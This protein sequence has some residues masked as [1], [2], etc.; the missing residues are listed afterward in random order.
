M[1]PCR[2]TDDFAHKCSHVECSRG[3]DFD[4]LQYESKHPSQAS[5]PTVNSPCSQPNLD[6][7]M[8]KPGALG[9]RLARRQSPLIGSSRSES[10]SVTEGNHSPFNSTASNAEAIK[11][12]LAQTGFSLQPFLAHVAG[13]KRGGIPFP[14]RTCFS[15]P[16]KANRVVRC[17]VGEA[18]NSPPH[19]TVQESAAV[20]AVARRGARACCGVLAAC[21]VARQTTSGTNLDSKSFLFGNTVYGRHCKI[22]YHLHD[23]KWLYIDLIS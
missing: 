4:I 16:G 10:P 1:Y 11:G 9:H 3:R 17:T 19:N 18:C 21:R 15:S 20:G 22:S 14:K 7:D 6:I 5:L 2:D 8:G 23:P 12:G 13:G